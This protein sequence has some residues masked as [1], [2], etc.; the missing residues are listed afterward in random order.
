MKDG[1]WIKLARRNSAQP[2]PARFKPGHAVPQRRTQPTRGPLPPMPHAPDALE[3]GGGEVPLAKAGQHGHNQL[4]GVLGAS[5]DLGGAIWQQSKSMLK[6]DLVRNQPGVTLLQSLGLQLC[7]RNLPSANRN[8][9]MARI[10]GR[11]PKHCANWR[12]SPECPAAQPHL[13]C[14][15]HRRARGDAAQEP[16]LQRQP[17]RHLYRVVAADLR[18]AGAE[19]GWEGVAVARK[20]A[21]TAPVAV[22][23]LG[24][25]LLRTV[26]RQHSDTAQLL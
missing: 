16:L 26:T 17:P 12:H 18:W 22:P 15:H 20:R 13:G 23:Q 10:H 21:T 14:C 19:P 11:W 9:K 25:L 5:S 3:E 7:R 1:G 2:C 24:P 8:I 6:R 4:A